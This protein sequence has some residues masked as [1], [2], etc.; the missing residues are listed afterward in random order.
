MVSRSS[1][2]FKI[3]STIC[4]FSWVLRVV[5]LYRVHM[6]HQKYTDLFHSLSL[7]PVHN[8]M[9]FSHIH[10]A[11]KLYM[12]GGHA[13]VWSVIMDNQ[14]MTADDPVIALH[15]ILDLMVQLRINLTLRSKAASVSL[16][17]LI[18]ASITSTDTTRPTRPSIL[19]FQI[20]YTKMETMVA[21]VAPHPPGNLP[22][23]PSS[24]MNESVFPAFC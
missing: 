10:V 14:I 7:N 23:L 22:R 17:I 6:D 21:V 4:F 20:P 11:G 9:R 24:P 8:F 12:D 16:A 3:W 13:S 5:H 15:K 2:P 19:I 1:S 18:P